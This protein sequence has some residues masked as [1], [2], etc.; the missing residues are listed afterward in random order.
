MNKAQQVEI[1]IILFIYNGYKIESIKTHGRLFTILIL[2][3]FLFLSFFLILFF[4]FFF[5]SNSTLFNLFILI[6]LAASL[7]EERD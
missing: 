1:S 2:L 5:L 3:L 7:F 4:F 6:L